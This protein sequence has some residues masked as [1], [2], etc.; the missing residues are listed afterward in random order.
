MAAVS[1]GRCRGRPVAV[2][3]QWQCEREPST[4]PRRAPRPGYPRPRQSSPGAPSGDSRPGSPRCSPAVGWRGRRGSQAVPHRRDRR[5]GG[6]PRVS[7]GRLRLQLLELLLSVCGD[8]A[9]EFPS[10]IQSSVS[11][12]QRQSRQELPCPLPIRE[13]L[14][15]K[16]LDQFRFLRSSSDRKQHTGQSSSQGQIRVGTHQAGSHNE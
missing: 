3:W 12:R 6:C 8:E 7:V 10:R 9:L 2:R 4:R 14:V 11:T 16:P 15:T 1:K 13:I 5:S